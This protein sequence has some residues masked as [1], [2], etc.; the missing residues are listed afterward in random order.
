MAG[1]FELLTALMKTFSTFVT[2]DVGRD[3]E[4][5]VHDHLSRRCFVVSPA[6]RSQARTERDEVLRTSSLV[7]SGTRGTGGTATMK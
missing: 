2:V 3:G 7:S 5:P 6:A 1:E 4:V